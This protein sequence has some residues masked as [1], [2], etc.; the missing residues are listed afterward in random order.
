M[1]VLLVVMDD[2]RVIL[3]RLYE[4]IRQNL[5]SCVLVRL[6]KAQQLHL[7]RVLLEQDYTSFDRVVIFSRLK[8]L[9]RQLAVLRGIPGLIF[10]E[11]DACQNYMVDSKYRGAYSRF[12]RRLP[13]VRVLVSGAAVA[14]RLSAEGVDAV[15]VSK[16]YDEQMFSNLGG[17][18][19]I[20]AAFLGSIKG[21]A[22]SPRRQVLDA[23][24]AQTELLVTRTRSGAEYQVML[25]RIRIFVSADVGM[26]EF[27]IKNFEA[28]ACGCVLLAWDQGDEGA[29]LGF[30][31][32]RNVLFYDSADAAVEKIRQLRADPQLAA[33]IANAGQALAE[34]HFTFKRVGHDL[35][36]AIELP[37]RPWPGLGFWQRGWLRLRYGLRI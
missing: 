2:Q 37:L 9:R 8:R 31:D 23:I 3:D 10:L 22:Y 7:A 11:H 33:R 21:D 20:E 36:R 18:R 26:G 14:R 32:G 19:D 5:Q 29:A 13:W 28:M 30:E 25:N 17:V 35:A 16:G 24:A 6:E 12:Y 15:F 27:M 1:K 34:Q 4:Q